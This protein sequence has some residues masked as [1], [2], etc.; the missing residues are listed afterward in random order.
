MTLALSVINPTVTGST[1]NWN[2]AGQTGFGTQGLKAV[3]AASGISNTTGLTRG[4]GVTATGTAVSGAWGG[5]G[6]AATSAG[7]ITTNATVTFGITLGN[8]TSSLSSITMNYLRSSTGPTNALWQYQKS[9]G[10][11]TTIGDFAGQFSDSSAT[12]AAITP[13]NLSGISELQNLIGGTTINFRVIPYGST[14][15]T[16]QWYIKNING[17]DLTVN[18]SVFTP[19]APLFN[20]TGGTP[21]L[22]NKKGITTK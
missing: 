18:G 16:G 19:P 10:T 8:V 12:G 13:I 21:L 6:W 14:D 5:T 15:S 9:G 11:W 17:M 1:V 2:V 4:S 7:G 20:P 22:G 3:T